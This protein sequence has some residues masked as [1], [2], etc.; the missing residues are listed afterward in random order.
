MDQLSIDQFGDRLDLTTDAVAMFVSDMLT[1][2]LA[3]VTDAER[4]MLAVASLSIVL[5]RLIN[6]VEETHPE[7]AESLRANA[8]SQLHNVHTQTQ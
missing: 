2:E 1:E 4:L 6:N 7:V 3:D 5:S 8:V